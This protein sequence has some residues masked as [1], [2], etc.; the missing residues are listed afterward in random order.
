M[1]WLQ[2]PYKL[3][4]TLSWGSVSASKL[5]G[6]GIVS[7]QALIKCVQDESAHTILEAQQLR[8]LRQEDCKF[9]LA[10]TTE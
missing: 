5:V 10:Y 3:C 8:S 4:P 1:A 6:F 7:I 9:K 2:G